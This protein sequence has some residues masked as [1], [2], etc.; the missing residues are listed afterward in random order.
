MALKQARHLILTCFKNE[1]PFI[2]EWLAYHRSIGFDG[3]L[4][5]TNDSDDGTDAL[6]ARLQDMDLLQVHDN[7]R[8]EGQ[9]PSHQ[10]RAFRKALR[11]PLYQNA[12]WVAL[13]D[14]DEFINIRPGAGQI[15][16]L[17]GAV[18][19]ANTISLAWRLFGN[20]GMRSYEPGFLTEQLTRAAREFAPRPPQAWGMKSIIRPGA[21]EALGV[22][23]PRQ[24][25]G[26]D[27]GPIHWVNGDGR[28][29]DEDF[30]AGNWRFSRETIGYGLGQVN[31]YAL[32]NRET[33]LLKQLRGRAFGG[34]ALDMT[35]WNRMNRN[36]EEDLSIA[37]MLPAARAEFARLMADDVL[38]QLHAQACEEHRNR[39]AA[40]LDTQEARAFLQDLDAA[41]PARARA[42]TRAR[43]RARA[44]TGV[45]PGAPRGEQ[46]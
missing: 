43:T 34:M 30:Y 4:I 24:P 25:V 37:R 27:W 14:A 9:R 22:H 10:G 8:R 13:I 29:M 23:R 31:H 45:G 16:D 17:T 1:A 39:I 15:G 33:F 35:Y 32:R 21:Y 3:F 38:A 28:R 46:K 12:E 18:P 40:V 6:L 2:L 11:N 20:A 41:G 7:T 5:Y 26:G 42:R 44:R 19:E 36:E